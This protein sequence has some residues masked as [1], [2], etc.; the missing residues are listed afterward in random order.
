MAIK[1][2]KLHKKGFFFTF[3]ATIIVSIFFIQFVAIPQAQN[4]EKV[5]TDKIKIA[6]IDDFAKT[7]VDKYIPSLLASTTKQIFIDTMKKGKV[8]FAGFDAQY[9]QLMKKNIDPHLQ[10]VN[11]IANRDLNI[12]TELTLKQYAIKQVSPYLVE[13]TAEME[14]KIASL[15]GDIKFEFGSPTVS[16]GTNL[17]II[18]LKDPLFV[19]TLGSYEDARIINATNIV[20]WGAENTS[21][22]M[23]N[24]D[25]RANSGAP[26]F[27][28]RFTGNLAHSSY[29]IES[30]IDRNNP[31][32]GGGEDYVDVDYRFLPRKGECKDGE[33]PD[34]LQVSGFGGNFWL[35]QNHLTLYDVKG[36]VPWGCK[37]EG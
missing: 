23:E 11:E 8:P 25:Y 10:L 14:L 27:L 12:N 7:L 16:V 24:E 6:L 30:L 20:S 36:T 4:S 17:S 15:Q 1:L 32:F 31:L 13:I 33:I 19:A 37:K 22:F 3:L 5:E 28:G 26:D 34:L 29:G 18:G 9:P 21:I 35:D 2:P